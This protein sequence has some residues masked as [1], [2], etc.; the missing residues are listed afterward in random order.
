[1]EEELRELKAAVL[2]IRD[3]DSPRGS[4][5]PGSS[6]TIAAERSLLSD[7]SQSFSRSQSR[8][9]DDGDDEFS[10]ETKTASFR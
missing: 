1:M 10:L 8:A 2:G 3:T 7:R 5:S 6:L 9:E 4:H